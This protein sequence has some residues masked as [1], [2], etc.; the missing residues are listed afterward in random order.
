M[1]TLM[2]TSRRV[3]EKVRRVRVEVRMRR[4][5]AKVLKRMLM[6]NPR[7]RRARKRAIIKARAKEVKAVKIKSLSR[8][9][10]EIVKRKIRTTLLVGIVARTTETTDLSRVKVLSACFGLQTYF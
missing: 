9:D 1:T 4:A 6:M 3:R 8:K 2:M 10:L 7:R 5:R